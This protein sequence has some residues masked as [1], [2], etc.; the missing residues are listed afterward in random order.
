MAGVGDVHADGR[1]FEDCRLWCAGGVQCLQC[2]LTGETVVLSGG[3]NAKTDEQFDATSYEGRA[4][5]VGRLGTDDARTLVFADDFFK[6]SVVSEV[7]PDFE[8]PQRRIKSRVQSEG[9]HSALS[10]HN[11]WV[12][13]DSPGPYEAKVLPC[14][15]GAPGDASAKV[16]LAW[17]FTSTSCGV[18]PAISMWCGVPRVLAYLFGRVDPR[19]RKMNSKAF[20]HALQGSLES[21]NLPAH[22]FMPSKEGRESQRRRAGDNMA[23]DLGPSEACTSASSLALVLAHMRWSGHWKFED[24]GTPNRCQLLSRALFDKLF[25]PLV[26]RIWAA[27]SPWPLHVDHGT[28]NLVELRKSPAG[29]SICARTGS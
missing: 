29:R 11:V 9:Y 15:V 3:P 27:E 28:V 2:A 17:F 13:D 25:Q 18:E 14:I 7:R 1:R 22:G 20:I 5:L 4:L 26:L 10:K 21:F 12:G 16:H 19:R 24:P 8:D 6:Y 23:W